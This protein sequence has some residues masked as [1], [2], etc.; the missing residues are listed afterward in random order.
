MILEF[1]C[2]DDTIRLSELYLIGE[3]FVQQLKAGSRVI[4]FDVLNILAALSVIFLHCNGNSFKFT[5]DLAWLQAITIEVVCYWAVPVFIMLSGANLM[6]YRDKYTTSEFFKKRFI[7]TVIPFVFWSLIVAAEKSINPFETGFRAF[8]NDFV[9]CKIEAVYWF[10]IP[11]F[12]VYLAIPVISCLK[13]NHKILWYM[14]FGALTVNSLLPSIFSYLGLSWNYSFAM[15]SVGGMLIFTVLGYLFS[16]TDFTKKQRYV[17]YALAI[18]AVL[19]KFAGT[20]IF[21][22]K[23]GTLDKTF[24]GYTSYIAVLQACGVFLFFKQSNIIKKIAENPQISKIISRI[25][26]C[27]FGIYLMHMIVYRFLRRFIAEFHWEW[28]LIVPFVIYAI[29]LLF[30]YLLKKIPVIK[31]IVP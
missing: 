18:L 8:I 31:N 3:F 19:V 22:Y 13:D 14:A 4:Y 9:N 27:S 15:Q 21:S 17:I 26:A 2:E 20:V 28:R 10:F 23:T 25:S 29:C 1:F 7:K 30:T 12:A 16:V 24:Y 5:G 11:L 6:N